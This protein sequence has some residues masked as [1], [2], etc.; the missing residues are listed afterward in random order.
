MLCYLVL[1]K[2]KGK[3]Y[4]RTSHKGPEGS[5]CIAAL[6]LIFALESGEWSKP[7]PVY[8]TPKKHPVLIV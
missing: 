6:S 2:G 3:V 1:A 5:R 7:H 8:F 4:P